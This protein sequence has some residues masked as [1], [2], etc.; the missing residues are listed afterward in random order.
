MGPYL[1]ASSRKRPP[2]T[3]YE[4]CHEMAKAKT[5]CIPE[6]SAIWLQV[7]TQHTP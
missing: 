1:I 4:L 7:C 3:L 5:E 2:A 6:A